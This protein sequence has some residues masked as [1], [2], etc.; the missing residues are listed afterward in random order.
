MNNKTNNVV[1]ATEN[2]DHEFFRTSGV[3]NFKLPEFTD[4][5]EGYPKEKVEDT[6]FDTVQGSSFEERKALLVEHVRRNPGNDHVKGFFYDILRI[7]E[8]I[9]PVHYKGLY[10]ALAYIN[11]R[12]DCADFVVNGIIRLYKQFGDSLSDNLL[13][14]IEKSILNFKYWPD[15]LE[16]PGSDSMCFWTEKPPYYI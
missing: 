6:Y 2:F 9:Q 12:K 10:S 8:N 3:E 13:S 4:F 15:E 14:A 11:S 7:A 1:N 16:L 5:P